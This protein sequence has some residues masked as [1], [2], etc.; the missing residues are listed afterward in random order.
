MGEEKTAGGDGAVSPKKTRVVET[1]VVVVGDDT[2][3][4]FEKNEAKNVGA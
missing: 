2:I 3:S 1:V 4:D